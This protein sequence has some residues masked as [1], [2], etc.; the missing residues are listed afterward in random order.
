M[1]KIKTSQIKLNPSDLGQILLEDFCPQCFWFTKKFPVEDKH[2]FSSPMPGIV[3]IADSYIKNVVKWHIQN[4]RILP[5]WILNQLNTI[6]PNFDFQNSKQIKTGRWEV[7]LFSNSCVLRGQADEV[8]EFPDG[9][10]FIIDYKLASLTENQ[11]KLLPLYEAQLN[12]YA[13]L[14]QKK[15]RKPIAGLALLYFVPEHKDL[16]DEIILHRTKDQFLFGF[17]PTIVPVKLRGPEWVEDLCKNLFEILSSD[18]PP[19]GKPN[20]Q[21]CNLLFEWLNK[22]SNY[23][24]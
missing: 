9:S 3:G 13:Y 7:L 4:F 16:Q 18:K 17:K 2:P 19:K 24:V 5:S 8:L 21:G 6:Y 23:L 12:A 1:A 11:K 20:C 22:I 15:F 10:W 14:A